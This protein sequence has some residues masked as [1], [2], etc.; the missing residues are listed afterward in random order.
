MGAMNSRVFGLEKLLRSSAG[1][2]YPGLSAGQ[3]GVDH[4]ICAGSQPRVYLMQLAGEMKSSV[5]ESKHSP[6]FSLIVATLGRT[7][8][9]GTLFESIVASQVTD[10]EVIVVDQNRDGSLDDISQRYSKKF[11]LNHLKVDFNGLSRAR[12]LRRPVCLGEVSELS[13][14]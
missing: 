4:S 8:E 12:K 10:L 1:Y 9:L 3:V 11:S 5:H 6:T 7:K 2:I 14:R 13:R